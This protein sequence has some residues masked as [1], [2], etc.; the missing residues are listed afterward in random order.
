LGRPG[1]AIAGYEQAISLDAGNYVY[2]GRLGQ[3]YFA[4]ARYDQAVVTLTTAVGLNAQY[5][6]GFY[7]LGL[8]HLALGN[9]EAARTAFTNCTAVAQQDDVQ[10]SQCQEQLA[11]LVTPMP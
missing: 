5:A 8:A 4:Q 9:A 1:D 11:P 7:Y 6:P 10:R 2:Y 3:L